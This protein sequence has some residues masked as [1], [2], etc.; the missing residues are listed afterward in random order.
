LFALIS[1]QTS[2]EK[3]TGA[4]DRMISKILHNQITYLGMMTEYCEIKPDT[5]PQSQTQI[6]HKGDETE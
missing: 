6:E 5:P 1:L 2:E 4:I 3:H